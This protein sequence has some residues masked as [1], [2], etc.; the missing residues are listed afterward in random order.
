MSLGQSLNVNCFHL[1][2][3]VVLPVWA[4]MALLI[5][6]ELLPHSSMILLTMW[7][8]CYLGTVNQSPKRWPNSQYF[9]TNGHF[10]TKT[11]A[12]VSIVSSCIECFAS[13]YTILLTWEVFSTWPVLSLLI[14]PFQQ[15]NFQKLLWHTSISYLAGHSFMFSDLSIFHKWLIWLYEIT[16]YR[17][18]NCCCPVC[19]CLSVC[20]L[21][22]RPEILVIASFNFAHVHTLHVDIHIFISKCIC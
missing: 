11:F 15:L 22:Y 6:L 17:I 2:A 1:T 9:S 10:H 19:V 20:R 3:I 4:K 7:K 8:R 18:T 16:A 13:K 14:F 12:D 5:L 21:S